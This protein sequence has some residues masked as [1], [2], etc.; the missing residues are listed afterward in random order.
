M[1]WSFLMLDQS[2]QKTSRVCSCQERM[3]TSYGGLPC[4]LSRP[5]TEQCGRRTLSITSH[6]LTE[7]SPDTDAS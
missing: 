1:N 7:P 4:S 5:D 3:G 2:T 6:S